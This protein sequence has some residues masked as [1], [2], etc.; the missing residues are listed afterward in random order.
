[1]KKVLENIVL[2]G[3]YDEITSKYIQDIVMLNCK[4]IVF[5]GP[6]EN[7]DIKMPVPYQ[8]RHFSSNYQKTLAMIRA[9][10]PRLVIAGAEEYLGLITRLQHDLHLPGNSPKYIDIYTKKDAMHEALKKAGVRYIRGEIANSEKEAVEVYRKLKC[11]EVIIKPTHSSS[12]QGL[13]LCRNEKELKERA[14]NYFTEGVK[15][16][17]QVFKTNL[18]IQERIK[19]D[20]YFIN[21]ITRHGKHKILQIW[22]YDIVETK[23]GNLVFPCIYS[24]NKLTPDLTPLINYC[25]QALDALHI[26][27]DT[28]HTEFYVD[29]KGPIMVEVNCR[30]S[31]G[32]LKIGY[33]DAI[34]GHHDTDQILNALL[35]PN[36]FKKRLNE[37]YRSFQYGIVKFIVS[38]RAFKVKSCPVLEIVKRLRSFYSTN[39]IP[40]L[41]GRLDETISFRTMGGFIHLLHP[42]QKVI[43]EDNRFLRMME[44]KFFYLLFEDENHQNEVLAKRV[45]KG[46]TL[47]KMIPN[48]VS[49]GLTIVLND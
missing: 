17:D 19:G 40:R 8:V 30:V 12:S 5:Y 38:P 41:S 49:Q 35:F 1:M 22:K 43:E 33:D 47:D 42:E 24:I 14:H 9:L 48:I 23:D 29:K 2:I 37:P 39:S 26:V 25:K 10:H 16:A 11:K 21:T 28:A 6:N 34:F 3:C 15:T 31:G 45:A 18:L 46:E 4:P 13:Y 32:R 7:E 20:E 44:Q 36:N 27:D